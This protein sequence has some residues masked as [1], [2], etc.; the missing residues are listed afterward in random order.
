M[1]KD[2]KK[3]FIVLA[4]ILCIIIPCVFMLNKYP[5]IL[6]VNNKENNKTEYINSEKKNFKLYKNKR[7]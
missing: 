7:V 4:L 1:N 3:I 2:V 5:T 6:F